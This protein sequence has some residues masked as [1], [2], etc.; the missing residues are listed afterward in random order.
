V[1]NIPPKGS[2]HRGPDL[3]EMIM[4]SSCLKAFEK[5][6]GD[7]HALNQWTNGKFW[8][9]VLVKNHNSLKI[10][11][12]DIE[13]KPKTLVDINT[14]P[15][16]AYDAIY[17]NNY[18]A[19][20]Y[21][22]MMMMII[23]IIIITYFLCMVIVTTTKDNFAAQQWKSSAPI[24]C[25]LIKS[26]ETRRVDFFCKEAPTYFMISKRVSMMRNCR[27]IIAPYV[28]TQRH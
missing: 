21:N 16:A 2:G 7:G 9:K 1:N 22:H 11:V 17:R 27:W 4:K 20:T 13:L 6:N 28:E 8:S 10:V 23:I 3:D 19:K 12:W 14:S 15:R 18:C 25:T 5:Y 24:K 26:L